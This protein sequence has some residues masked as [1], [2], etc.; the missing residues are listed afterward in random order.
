MHL[1][2]LLVALAL[3]WLLRL[4]PVE[5]TG[6]WQGRWQRSLGVFLL[7][8]ILLL[9]TAVALL[10][11]GP[12]GEM[13]CWWEGWFSYFLAITFLVAAVT[14]L[15]RLALEGWR[16]LRQVQS[17]PQFEVGDVSTR[18]L[19]TS[20]P[21][22]ARI[23]FWQSELVVSQ[24]LV[25]S[26][27]SDH[28]EAVLTHEQAHHHYRDTFW[29]F[30]LGWLRRLTFWLPQTE[31]LWQELLLLREHRADCWASQRVD[32]LLLAES[33]LQ[34]VSAPELY[35]ATICA[36]FS[37][38]IPPTRLEERIDLLLSNPNPPRQHQPWLW[39]WLLLGMLPLLIVPFH[40]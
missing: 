25:N 23:G 11:M 32:S 36:A 39:A 17:Y 26:F 20:I 33:L 22:I 6:D 15:L 12:K 5:T 1:T 10:C 37:N 28:L 30:W 35:S 34:M 29:F 2:I 19:S 4:K 14:L 27:D 18:L 21:F 7:S 31:T 3:A 13:V 38:A 16:S 24:G 40:Y 9:A 8:P